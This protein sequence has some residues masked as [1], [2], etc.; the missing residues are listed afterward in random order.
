MN[1]MKLTI[2]LVPQTAWYTNVRSNVSKN[3]WD[4]LRKKCY[5]DANYKCEI[6]GGRGDKWPVECHEIWEYDDINKKQILKG[7]IALCPN[8]H[9]V[10]HAGLAR[11]N[12]EADLVVNQLMSVNGISKKDALKYIDDSFTIWKERSKSAWE[13][14]ISCL[15]RSL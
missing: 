10:K 9:K 4:I 14:D 8:C 12:G 2:E 5:K 15:E 13:C 7:L 6:C 3:K 11:M 1:N